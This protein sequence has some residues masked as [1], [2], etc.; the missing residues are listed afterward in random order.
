M[1]FDELRILGNHSLSNEELAL[2]LERARTMA[3]ISENIIAGGHLALRAQEL[4][5]EYDSARNVTVPAY[6]NGDKE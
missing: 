4:I 1:L 3:K 6:L 2:E 5:G